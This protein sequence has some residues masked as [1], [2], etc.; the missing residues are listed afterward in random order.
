M[1]RHQRRSGTQPPS[2]RCIVPA[3]RAIVQCKRPLAQFPK[4]SRR[5]KSHRPPT[6]RTATP[7]VAAAAN[8]VT[9]RRNVHPAVVHAVKAADAALTLLRRTADV[10]D[11]RPAA[12]AGPIARSPQSVYA[13]AV[14]IFADSVPVCARVPVSA[15]FPRP[16]SE[17]ACTTRSDRR[18]YP[19]HR[20]PHPARGAT[21]AAEVVRRRVLARI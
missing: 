17:H 14:P 8:D 13:V 11:D 15:S 20:A 19:V 9:A 1:R 18:T 7:P 6:R 12:L 5:A 2:R 3:P 4:P 21:S 10:P 16:F